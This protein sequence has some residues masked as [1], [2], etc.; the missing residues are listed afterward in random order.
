MAMRDELFT[1]KLPEKVNFASPID[2]TVSSADRIELGSCSLTRTGKYYRTNYWPSQASSGSYSLDSGFDYQLGGRNSTARLRIF[3]SSDVSFSRTSTSVFQTSS[4]YEHILDTDS[5]TSLGITNYLNF[6]ILPFLSF[7]GEITKIDFYDY[8]QVV[9]NG[10]QLGTYLGK[11]GY[12]I[13]VQ[14]EVVGLLDLLNSP[15]LY[16]AAN[17]AG[18]MNEEIMKASLILFEILKCTNSQMYATS[19]TL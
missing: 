3:H 11:V 16:L 13:K 2:V 6:G 9:D 12:L 14:G 15:R 19:I 10:K 18:N 4:G 7:N 17:V 8:H 5:S 1:T